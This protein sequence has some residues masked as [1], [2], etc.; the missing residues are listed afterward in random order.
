MS[1]LCN[2]TEGINENVIGTLGR[3]HIRTAKTIHVLSVGPVDCG[4]MV[5][6]SLLEGPSFRLSIE[7]DYRKLWA[8]P[9][10]ESIEVAILHSTLSLFELEKACRLIRQR[11]PR[12]RILVVRRGEDFLDDPLYDDCVVPTVAPDV[13]LAAIERLLEGRHEWRAEDVEH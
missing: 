10:L 12:S 9:K 13:L 1:R 2:V 11:W 3:G 8:I 5:H 7:P 4:C 6:D